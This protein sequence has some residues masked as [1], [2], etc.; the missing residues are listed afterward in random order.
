MVESYGTEVNAEQLI[1]VSVENVLPPVGPTADVTMYV[2]SISLEWRSGAPGSGPLP[3]H[4]ACV[5]VRSSLSLLYFSF[6]FS[7]GSFS[8]WNE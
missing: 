5:E 2:D 6:F 3:V 8:P 7:V 1:C 4:V